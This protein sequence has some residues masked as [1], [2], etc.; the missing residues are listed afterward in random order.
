VLAAGTVIGG[1]YRLVREVGRGGMATVW[2]AL[3]LTLHVPV[4]VK[5]LQIVGPNVADIAKRFL[6]EARVAAAI[7]HRNV[8]EIMDFGVTDEERIPYMVME[9]LTGES[10]ADKLT[11]DRYVSPAEAAF[12][13][14]LSL[15]GLSVVHDSGIVHRDL[16]PENIFLVEDP[17]GTYPKLLD[18]GVSRKLGGG[19]SGLTRQGKRVGTPDYM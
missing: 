19:A 9:L 6:Q 16:K 15:R 4:A 17:D 1:R 13:A 7:R 11:R 12:I 10:L 2:E 5:F 18:F 3:H 8:I 14:S